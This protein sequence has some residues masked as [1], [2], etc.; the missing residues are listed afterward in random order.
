MSAGSKPEAAAEPVEL[1]DI[2]HVAM[3][4]VDAVALANFYQRVLGFRKVKRPFDGIFD[5]VWLRGGGTMIHIMAAN[6]YEVIQKLQAQY[7]LK[8][9]GYEA[10]PRAN[11]ARPELKPV[12]G[13]LPLEDHLAFAVSDIGT[14]RRR[15]K[16]L[17]I[18]CFNVKD[19]IQD[20]LWLQDPDGRII[21]LTVDDPPP[22]YVEEPATAAPPQSKL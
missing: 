12:D 5:G 15:L 9:P 8:V 7:N 18:E 11:V 20:H 13:R 10:P 2:N 6:A 14:T 1:K 3:Q 22:P 17:G 4:T 19:K 16:A 21:E